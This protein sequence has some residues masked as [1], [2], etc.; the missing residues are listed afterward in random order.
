[1]KIAKMPLTKMNPAHYN[2]RQDLQPGDPDYDKLKRGI[3]EFGLVEPLVWNQRTG[4][5]VGGHQRLKVLKDL[6]YAEA[7][8]SVVD[9]D[10]TREKALNLALNKISGEWDMPKLKDLL[11]KLDTGAFDMEI[12]GFDEKELEQLMTQ[13]HVDPKEEWVGMPEFKAEPR[14]FRSFMVHFASADDLLD[15]QKKIGREISDK[16]KYIWHPPKEKQDL[17]SQEW[18]D[19]DAEA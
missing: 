14:A 9:L 3:Q 6:G 8:V 4:R 12:T 19:G 18:V 13:Y 11:E 7:Q 10:E 5:L 2:P 15:F 1:M 17:K 16:A